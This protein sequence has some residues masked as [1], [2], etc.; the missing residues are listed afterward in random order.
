MP[1]KRS[2]LRR[3]LDDSSSD[4]DDFE[5]LAVVVTVD[6]FANAEKKHGGSVPAHRVLYRDREGGHVRMFQDFLAVNPTYGPEIFRRRLLFF[7]FRLTCCLCL[8]ISRVV[9]L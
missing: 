6:T 9:K 7:H 5:I 2:L 1:R 4:D 3:Q 8:N